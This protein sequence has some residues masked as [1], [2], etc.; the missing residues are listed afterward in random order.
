MDKRESGRGRV[1]EAVVVAEEDLTIVDGNA[2][3]WD[4]VWADG[5]LSPRCP[6]V[7]LDVVERYCESYASNISCI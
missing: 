2:W 3:L 7:V 5:P 1:G 6:N 4:L